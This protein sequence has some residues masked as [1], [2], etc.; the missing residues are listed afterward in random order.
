MRVIGHCRR[1]R[2][3][4]SALVIDGTDI[5]ESERQRRS[6]RYR[7]QFRHDERYG[8]ADLW[9]RSVIVI[10]SGS[11]VCIAL[12]DVPILSDPS[13]VLLLVIRACWPLE[14]GLLD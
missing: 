2:W 11:T 6:R 3:Q 10:P 5:G 8:L 1:P 4:S 14:C 9:P 12:L 7:T 13:Q